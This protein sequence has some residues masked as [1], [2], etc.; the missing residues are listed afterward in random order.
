MWSGVN[1]KKGNNPICITVSKLKARV[2]AP[3]KATTGG[4]RGPGGGAGEQ[5]LTA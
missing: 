1:V 3:L 2:A 4:L 5:D